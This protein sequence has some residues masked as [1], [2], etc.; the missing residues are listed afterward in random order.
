M[1]YNRFNIFSLYI[2]RN[3]LQNTKIKIKFLY[4][5]NKKISHKSIKSKSN[6]RKNNY[7]TKYNK[8]KQNGQLTKQIKTPYSQILSV[9]IILVFSKILK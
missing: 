5:N 1:L 4:K 3:V 9:Y 8:Y 2:I 7:Q 6:Q